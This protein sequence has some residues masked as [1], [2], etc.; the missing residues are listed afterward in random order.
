LNEHEPSRT[1]QADPLDDFQPRRFEADGIGKTVW[2]SGS[3]PA[4]I[5]MPEMPGISPDVARF[6]RWI[7]EAG[8]IVFLPEQ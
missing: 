5:V 8:F 4:V 1:T 2:V 6:A 7:R 3:G